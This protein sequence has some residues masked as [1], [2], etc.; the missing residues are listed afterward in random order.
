MLVAKRV[1][2]VGRVTKIDDSRGSKKYDVA[3]VLGGKEKGVDEIYVALHESEQSTN[4]GLTVAARVSRSAEK[5]PRLMRKRRARQKKSE[6]SSI[7]IYN[8]DELQQIPAE[9][10]E[11]AG[12]RPAAK[13]K[14][15]AKATGSKSNAPIKNTATKK[16]A[17]AE[18]SG[19]V[20]PPKK[21][22]K[23]NIASN[24]DKP[25]RAST[26]FETAIDSMKSS[27][28]MCAADTR[29]SKL[30]SVKSDDAMTF[31]VVTSNLSDDETKI[32]T[33]LTKMLKGA[34][35]RSTMS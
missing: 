22:K 5:A 30:L 20:A 35:G 4:S 2:G 25:D 1:L 15:S 12:I 26:S 6:P 19:N 27:E 3:Y 28:L 34:N 21:P 14:R 7:P 8:D 32:L 23:Q 10:L 16:R 17:L 24:Q 29:Y 11:W 33:S 31:H 9:V 13:G 18:T